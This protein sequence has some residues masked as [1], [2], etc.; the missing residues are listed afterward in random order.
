MSN[1]RPSLRVAYRCAQSRLV[2]GSPVT[3]VTRWASQVS[4]LSYPLICRH[5]VL[6]SRL[7]LL[8]FSLARLTLNALASARLAP[9]FRDRAAINSPRCYYFLARLSSFFSLPFPPTILPPIYY[10]P[11]TL[12]RPR[13][14][15]RGFN[16]GCNTHETSLI[17]SVSNHTCYR[18]EY[19]LLISHLGL[20]YNHRRLR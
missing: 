2:Q 6:S 1:G 9:L 17:R 11:S 13:N 15:W 5:F 19:F 4:L 3:P 20:I 10:A 8:I 14:L 18:S 16:R 12:K 7:G